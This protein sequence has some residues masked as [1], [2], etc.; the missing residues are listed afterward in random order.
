VA[1]QFEAK[2]WSPM[3]G[4]GWTFIT[5][6]RSASAQL[7]TRG[8]VAVEGTINGFSF[9][10]SAFPDGDGSHNIMINGT[11]RKGAEAN[12]GD[13]ARFTLQAA[14]DAVAVAP[15][16][17]LLAALKKT[18]K[19]SAQWKAITPKAQAEWVNWITSAK[20]DETRAARVAKTI[21]RLEKGD[22]R[23]S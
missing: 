7:P 5:L 23:P 9:R 1:I 21:E 10:T 2:L 8:R 4:K 12:A 14:N 13:T 6:P 22:K 18:A 16:R 19:A 20:R 17:E 15:P 3:E 11:M